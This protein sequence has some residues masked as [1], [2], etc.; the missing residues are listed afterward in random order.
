[1]AIGFNGT[2][3]RIDYGNIKATSG[4]QTFSAWVYSDDE[5]ADTE[6]MLCPNVG[7]DNDY[8]LSCNFEAN[9]VLGLV[10]NTSGNTLKSYSDVAA[11]SSGVW[12]H[13]LYTW[14]GSLTAANIH[15]FVNNVEE[16]YATQDDGTGAVVAPAGIWP[17]GGLTWNDGSCLDG[18][19]AHV[20]WWDRVLTAG[21]RKALSKGYAPAFIPRGLK[22][23]PDLIRNQR[24]LISGE[25]GTLDG[26]SVRDHPRIINPFKT[27]QILTPSEAAVASGFMTC[28]AGY[29]GA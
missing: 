14:D 9:Y 22:F 4:A 28:N 10:V 1:M 19:L 29:W 23:A 27:S 26:T 7:A 20:G 18:G 5:P 8:A 21:E 13:Y 12:F 11:F 6:R 24:D 2:T 16:T 25:A 3:D 15:Q 17:L